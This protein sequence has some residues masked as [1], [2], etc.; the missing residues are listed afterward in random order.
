MR[1]YLETLPTFCPLFRTCGENF[2]NS[3]FTTLLYIKTL[4]FHAFRPHATLKVRYAPQE[5]PLEILQG[6][7]L[8]KIPPK[9]L[10]NN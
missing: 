6:H 2:G 4:A 7:L 9:S 10:L 8:Y 1:N 5:M 3:I